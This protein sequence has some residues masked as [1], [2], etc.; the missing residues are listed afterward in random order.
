M[1]FVNVIFNE[2][3]IR[4]AELNQVNPMILPSPIRVVKKYYLK[5]RCP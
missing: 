5:F 4:Y 1:E 2:F 3:H